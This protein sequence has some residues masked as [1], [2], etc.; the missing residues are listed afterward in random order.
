LGSNN[1]YDISEELAE[2]TA[3]HLLDCLQDEAG[4]TARLSI[5]PDDHI[6]RV[7]FYAKRLKALR[8]ENLLN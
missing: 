8:A 3:T 7:V 2:R 5:F 6:K 4:L 1:V